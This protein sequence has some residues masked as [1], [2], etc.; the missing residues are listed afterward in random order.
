MHKW[1]NDLIRRAP[2]GEGAGGEGAGGTGGEGG[3]GTGEGGGA[4]SGGE[5]GAWHAGLELPDEDR[6]FIETKGYKT[7]GDL[8]KAYRDAEAYQGRSIALPGEDAKPEDWGKLWNRL[9]R[10]E[11]ADGY[12]FDGVDLSKLDDNAKAALDWFKAQAHDQGLTT[13]QAASLYAATTRRG[14]EQRE[15]AQKAVDDELAA[16]DAEWGGAA[17]GNKELAK[18][19]AQALGMT[20]EQIDA[21]G[22]AMGSQVGIMK[23]LHQLAGKLEQAGVLPAG[24]H[25]GQ[26][27]GGLALGPEEAK[28]KIDAIYADPE[29]P[30]HRDNKRDPDRLAAVEEVRQLHEI[31]H[32]DQKGAAA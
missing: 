8:V 28:R 20:A 30:Y 31:A 9:G 26:G 13:R 23:S 12:R 14:A 16:L 11:T 2:D 21:L 19:A 7:P 4:G 10:P 15:A 17:E 24:P 22:A 6:Q 5:G 29:H 32:P 18:R 1:L 25:T 27:G 3:G